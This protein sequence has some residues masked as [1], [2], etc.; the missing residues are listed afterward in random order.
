[1][2]FLL[3]PRSGR[4]A[5]SNEWMLDEVKYVDYHSDSISEEPSIVN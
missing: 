5:Y 4:N 1:M 2:F 3:G